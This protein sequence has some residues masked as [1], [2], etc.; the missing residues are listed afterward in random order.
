MTEK[1]PKRVKEMRKACPSVAR[2][3]RAIVVLAVTVFGGGSAIEP[4][5]ETGRRSTDRP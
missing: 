4:R 2:D 5:H 1:T 3:I